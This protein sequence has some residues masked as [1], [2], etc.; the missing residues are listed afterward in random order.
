MQKIQTKKVEKI[1]NLY[2]FYCDHC[3]KY[4]GTSIQF[5][6]GYI[7]EL[8]KY[9]THMYLNGKGWLHYETTLCDDCKD[10]TINNIYNSLKNLG[11]EPEEVE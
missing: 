10:K 6:D 7:E 9:E 11:F 8:G 3:N 5:N 1:E 4:L 2:E